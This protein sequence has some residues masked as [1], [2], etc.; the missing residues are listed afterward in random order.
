MKTRTRNI[1][2]LALLAILFVP[3]VFLACID[4]SVE[5]AESISRTKAT[6][7]IDFP[8]VDSATN[9][10]CYLHAFG[11]ASSE[12]Y[13]RL[14]VAKTDI[15]K[16][17]NLAIADES[18]RYKRTP[19]YEKKEID[20]SEIV[21]GPSLHWWNRPISWWGPEKITNGYYMGEI[22]SF[23]YQIWVDQSTGTLF[24]FQCD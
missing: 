7:F 14:T 10:S 20:S 3:L 15:T 21:Q 4:E 2:F 24:I 8:L 9:I 23:G 6:N 16:Q 17:I 5:R 18:Q 13:L 19:Q 22:R 12:C 1:A 11:L